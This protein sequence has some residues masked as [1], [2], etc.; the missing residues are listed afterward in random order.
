MKYREDECVPETWDWRDEARATAQDIASD[1]RSRRRLTV[2]EIRAMAPNYPWP[3][4]RIT[5]TRQ[6]IGAR[7]VTP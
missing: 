7:K 1:M 2:T 4:R 3:D 5:T 6:D